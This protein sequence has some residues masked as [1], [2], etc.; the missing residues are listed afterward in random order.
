M[1]NFNMTKNRKNLSK[2]GVGIK[3][4][5]NGR[6]YSEIM[7]NRKHIHLGTFDKLTDAIQA[8]AKAEVQYFGKYRNKE[9]DKEIV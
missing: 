7:V 8:R 9:S 3:K 1:Y 6:Y 4:L 5:P 2:Y